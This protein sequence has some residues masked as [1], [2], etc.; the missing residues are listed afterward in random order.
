MYMNPENL[1]RVRRVR[2]R[3]RLAVIGSNGCLCT[4]DRLYTLLYPIIDEIL[5]KCQRFF[6]TESFAVCAAMSS[7]RASYAYSPVLHK[8]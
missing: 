4:S 2:L 1:F 3:V 6:I 7:S 8:R 5:K